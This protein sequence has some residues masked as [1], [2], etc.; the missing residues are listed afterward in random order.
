MHDQS[1]LLDRLED[2]WAMR[3]DDHR[4]ALLLEVPEHRQERSFSD[5]VK[6]GIGFIEYHH[7]RASV[8]GPGNSD[9]LPLSG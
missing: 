2:I 1:N 9:A 6:V 3:D 5:H 7:A 8:D 4:T